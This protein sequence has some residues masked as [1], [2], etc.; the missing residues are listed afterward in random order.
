MTPSEPTQVLPP[1]PQIDTG[2]VVTV[3]RD[4]RH[5]RLIKWLVII[6]VIA[7]VAVAAV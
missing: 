4:C 2:A 1:R 6:V 3:E 7:L 5:H